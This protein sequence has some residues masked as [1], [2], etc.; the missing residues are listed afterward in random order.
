MAKSIL[1]VGGGFAGF[2]AALAATRV[3]ASQ[4]Q[5]TLI[6]RSPRLVMRPRLYEPEPETLHADLDVPLATAGVAF[7]Q[8][9]AE[10][11]D[12]AAR[13]L[14]LGSGRALEFDRLVVATGSVMRRPQVPGAG[15]AYSIDTQA[16]AIALDRHLANC[17]HAPAARIIVIGA[18]FTGIE[19][20]LNMRDRLSVHAGP[21]AGAR[22]QITL[23]D[24]ARE[25]G[26]QLGAG[27]RPVIEAALD[28]AGIELRLGVQIQSLAA[29]EVCLQGGQRMR[30]SAVVLCTGLEAAPFLR[31]L[32]GERDPSGRIRVD[33]FL[34][35]PE[36]PGV[37][38]A[39]DAA[40][41][42]TGPGHTT[43]MSCQHAMPLGRIAGENAAR[44]LL[45]E[46]LTRYS[47]PRY[48]TCLDLGRS[49]AVLSE[50]WD[51]RVQATGAAAK[52]VKREINTQRIYPPGGGAGSGAR[53]SLERLPASD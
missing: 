7:V 26:P 22:A 31:N 20:A 50:G 35:I 45:G 17:A 23:L 36:S 47:Q 42:M 29:D 40:C 10:G 34:G 14:R 53:S 13:Q 49:G 19:L 46:P 3:A 2:H 52:A 21:E 39:G 8:D 15:Q 30:A 9:E 38:L 44:S 6:S 43:L 48:T 16:E 41:A 28:A 11:V 18:G 1:V 33:A 51:R 5:V 27:P 32:A 12:L 24:Q 37:F 4:A 25:L